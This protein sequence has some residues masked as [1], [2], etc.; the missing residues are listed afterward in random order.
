MLELLHNSLAHGDTFLVK[1]PNKLKSTI[2]KK[3]KIFD[4]N[5]ILGSILQSTKIQQS[6]RELSLTLSFKDD[7]Y[8]LSLPSIS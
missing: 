5:D 8:S 1:L 2:S 4:S 6:D 3:A 7:Q